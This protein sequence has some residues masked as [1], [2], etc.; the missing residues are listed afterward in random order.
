M[1]KLV[2]GLAIASALIALGSLAWIFARRIGW[3]YDLEWM[4]GGELCHALRLLQHQPIYAAPSVDFVPY[5]YTPLYPAVVAALA[6]VFGLGYT[7]GRAV[8]LVGFG[9]AWV[10]GYVFV[11][12]EGGSRA[13]ALCAMALPAAAFV[14]LGA[15]YDLARPD[16]LFLGLT[17][18]GLLIGWWKRQSTVGV[19][20]AA[21]LLVAA[22]FTKQTASPFLVALGL[23]LL[24]IDW[25]RALVYGVTLAA[26]G[27]P[28]LWWM[29]H[30]SGGWFWTYVFKLHQQ[31]DFYR[32]RAFLGS[33][34]RLLLLVG[35]SVLLVPW[36]LL[37]ERTPGLVYATF[38]AAAGAGVACLGFGTQWAFTNA[39]I[40]G[41]FFPAIAIGTAAGRLLT[42]RTLPRLRPQVVYALLAS[43]I[44]LAPGGLLPTAAR[45]FPRDWALLA[46]N[47]TPQVGYDPRFYLPTAQDRAKADALLAKLRATPGDVLIPF[48]P[49]Y[50]HLAGKRTFLHRMGV[51]D[52]GRAGL[53]APRGLAE[54][55]ANRQ[56]ALVVMDDKID[57]N[58]FWWPGLQ[59]RYPRSSRIAGPRVFS[60]AMTE[61]RYLLEPAVLERE[62]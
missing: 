50:G 58:W 54:A 5:L 7:L 47:V 62:P 30:D 44:A 32:G 23:A 59:Q 21:L 13:A 10:L 25:R 3:P 28:L 1:L 2:R 39:F 15:W 33:P 24:I 60:G 19:A 46:D 6:R 9:S 40:P 27:V 41:V 48:H 14:P 34:V 37:R 20:I 43:S 49:F 31:H 45:L 61:P 8:S 42:A 57:G 52:V 53:G 16:S 22:F 4:E 36:A 18:A 11:R 12:R 26:V 51:L 55:I 56:F 17:T 35:P 38:L 29:N